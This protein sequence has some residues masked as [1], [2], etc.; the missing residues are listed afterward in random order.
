MVEH[1][2]GRPDTVNCDDFV[3]RF[4]TTLQNMLKNLLLQIK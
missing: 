3:P 1:D 2:L 4:R